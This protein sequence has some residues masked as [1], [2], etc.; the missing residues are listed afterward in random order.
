MKLIAMATALSVLVFGTSSLVWAADTYG[1]KIS[2]GGKTMTKTIKK[3]H[4]VLSKRSNLRR[5]KK[6]R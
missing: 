5:S 3:E 2:T 6:N 1:N 4:K